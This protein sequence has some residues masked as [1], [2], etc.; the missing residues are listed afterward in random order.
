MNKQKVIVEQFAK[1][2]ARLEE[3]VALPSGMNMVERDSSIKRFE[4]CFDL[5]WKAV[6]ERLNSDGIECY[7]PKSCF[8]EAFRAK[9][10]EVT[11][12]P[13]WND[14]IKDRNRSVHIYSETMAD[15]I[16]RN[17]PNYIKLFQKIIV[18]LKNESGLF[19]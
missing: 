3:S 15:E 11:D 9:M 14:L 7:S 16:Y 19:S 10:I 6:K 18:T 17:L 5:C 12:E 1:A 2:I 13:Y 8:Q 4:I